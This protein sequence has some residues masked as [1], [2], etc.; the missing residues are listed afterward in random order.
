MVRLWERSHGDWFRQLE[1]Q[2]I[3]CKRSTI[4]LPD[5]TERAAYAYFLPFQARACF[6]LLHGTGND[7][8]FGWDLWIEN[9]VQQGYAVL[10]VDIEGH[11]EHSTTFLDP[12]TF[13]YT[14][15]GLQAWLQDLGW[16][17]EKLIVSGY[18]LGALFALKSLA[19]GSLKAERLILL[20]LPRQVKISWQFVLSEAASIFRPV[21]WRQWWRKGWRLSLPAL[22]WWRRQTFPLRLQNFSDKSYPRCIAF[23]FQTHEPSALLA[24]VSCPS[25]SIYGERDRLAP[26]PPPSAPLAAKSTT[27]VVRG[28]NHFLL[29][30][31]PEGVEGALRW[32]R[33][34]EARL[35]SS[36][37]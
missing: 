19:N 12:H 32:L 27:L 16:P 36:S 31:Y 25:L 30:W 9:L 29:T 1:S 22:G 8:L 28:A 13:T 17:P 10:A 20:A 15:Q 18:S 26:S 14:A 21:F 7:A 4:L 2:G 37:S 3:S 23:L 24:R 33:E 34:G 11:G 35:N 6:L 5:R